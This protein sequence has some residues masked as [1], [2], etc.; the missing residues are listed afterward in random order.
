MKDTRIHRRAW[1]QALASLTLAIP[2]SAALGKDDAAA[3]PAAPIRIV[4]AYPAGG[5]VDFVARSFA[6]HLGTALK[7]RVFVENRAGA[8]GSVGAALVARAK[9]DGYTL[10]LASPAE[11]VVGP[12]A[13]QK[14]PYDA[15][16]SFEP[17]GL[18]GETPLA[19]AAHP[20][21]GS[22]S[23]AELLEQARGGKSLSFGTPGGGS[24]MH[25][26]GESLNQIG[27]TTILHIPYK[28]AA[29]AVN[30][31]LGGQVPLAVVGLPPLIQHA[32]SGR[33]RVLAVT[34]EARSSALPNVP[35]VAELPGFAGFRFSNWMG[36]YAPAG[37][38]GPVVARLSALVAEIASNTAAR[39]AWQDAG[40]EPR[41]LDAKDF[42][43]F[44]HSERQR[45]A[46][47]AKERSIRFVE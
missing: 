41:G 27:R 25:F 46:S 2:A 42:T 47:I 39:K 35:A 11:V 17:V 32:K 15:Q 40:V 30:D 5:G 13:G 34:T 4:V 44:L 45:Y 1:L 16:A 33:I 9:A 29:P 6:E 21:V 22:G 12:A 14:V 8:S 36:L 18:L 43:A 31:L 3:W 26:A 24:P 37:T 7:Q 10:L 28:G 20:S 23:L 19:I 38:P